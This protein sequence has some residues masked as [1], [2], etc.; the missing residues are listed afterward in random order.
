M[1]PD[2]QREKRTLFDMADKPTQHRWWSQF[3]RLSAAARE[4]L[5]DSQAHS[6][7]IRG[8]GSRRGRRRSAEEKE[9]GL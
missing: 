5:T 1:S 2:E 7:A 4:H 3:V 8:L 6:R 9:L